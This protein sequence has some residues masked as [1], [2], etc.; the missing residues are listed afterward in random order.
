M[1]RCSTTTT[2]GLRRHDAD[3][4]GGES[5]DFITSSVELD[6]E[7]ALTA[8]FNWNFTY[9][10]DPIT[11][12]DQTQSA[13]GTLTF[14]KVADTFTIDDD[15]PVEG[16]SFSVLHTNELLRKAPPGNTGHPNR[17]DGT[18]RRATG[19]VATA[20]MSSSP[21]TPRPSNPLRVQ[22]DWRRARLV[23]TPPST[24]ATLSPTPT[25]IGFCHADHQR[26]GR[27]HDPEGRTAD[28]PLLRGEYPWRRQPER[29]GWRQREDGP[30]DD[31]R[32]HRH[33][34]RRHRNL[35]RLGPDPQPDRRERCRDH[36]RRQRPE[37][38]PDQGHANVPAP[39]NTEFTLDNNDALWSWNRTTTT[40]LARRSRFRASR[41]CSPRTD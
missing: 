17:G 33:Q 18:G 1:T 30:D 12:G 16:F 26:R 4:H 10:A 37:L 38:G 5:S 27:R 9:D 11:A 19:S 8:T 28:A 14:D 21:P 3:W 13:A 22:H 41:S 23:A 20:S 7:D 36:A 25:R 32:W 40:P 29:T 15:G 39:Y 6:S 24:T 35:G 34:V 2:A 31:G